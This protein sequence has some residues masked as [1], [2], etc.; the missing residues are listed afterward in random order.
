MNE[1]RRETLLRCGTN[2]RGQ[3]HSMPFSIKR[4]APS[5]QSFLAF[6]EGA[7]WSEVNDKQLNVESERNFP[8]VTVAAW[9]RRLLGSVRGLS[10]GEERR[11][12]DC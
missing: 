12:L 9:R 5:E 10:H 8:L 1:Q 6:G 2:K 11:F 3:V 4:D 7:G